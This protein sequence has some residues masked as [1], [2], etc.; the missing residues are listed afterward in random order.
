VTDTGAFSRC[1]NFFVSMNIAAAMRGARRTNSRHMVA[2]TAL[3]TMAAM[4]F[5]SR[6]LPYTVAKWPYRMRDVV[7]IQCD[8]FL[9]ETGDF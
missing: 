1:A 9:Y 5:A 8:Q 4:A 7:R 3:F 6:F 2:D